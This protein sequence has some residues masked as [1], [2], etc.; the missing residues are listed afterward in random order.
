MK[1]VITVFL[2]STFKCITAGREGKRTG[3][4]KSFLK[5]RETL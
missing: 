4:E 2:M 5:K 3:L 1:V